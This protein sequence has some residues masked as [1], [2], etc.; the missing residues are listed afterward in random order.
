MTAAALQ[1]MAA[2]LE[3]AKRRGDAPHPD[4][5]PTL[6]MHGVLFAIPPRRAAGV[7]FRFDADGAHVVGVESE[8]WPEAQAVAEAASIDRR[9]CPKCGRAL[10]ASLTVDPRRDVAFLELCAT[11][12]GRLLRRQYELTDD[13]LAGLLAFDAQASPDWV[14]QVVQWSLI[15]RTERPAASDGGRPW[16]KRVLAFFGT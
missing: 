12:A 7:S 10:A 6:R 2:R 11:L 8:S 13:E 1:S 5:C 16:S 15:G 3:V 4:E 14:A 9:S